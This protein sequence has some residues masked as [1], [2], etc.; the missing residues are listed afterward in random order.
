MHH[1]A[2]KLDSQNIGVIWYDPEP[3]EGGISI[4]RN[5]MISTFNCKKGL[6]KNLKVASYGDG[7]GSLSSEYR[8]SPSIFPI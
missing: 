1:S 3:V 5:T 4:K 7:F 8:F 2:F 6:W